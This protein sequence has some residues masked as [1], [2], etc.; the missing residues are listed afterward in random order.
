MSKEIQRYN[1]N[2]GL[3]LS[4]PPQLPSPEFR[5]G[6]APV[7]ENWLVNKKLKQM[8]AGS[9]HIKNIMQNTAEAVRLQTEIMVQTVTAPMKIQHEIKS[10]ENNLEMQNLQLEAQRLRNDEQRLKNQSLYFDNKKIEYEYNEMIKDSRDGT[11]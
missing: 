1:P 11:D 7:L 10:Y 9:E 5:P 3:M 4:K 6:L 2:T 8:E